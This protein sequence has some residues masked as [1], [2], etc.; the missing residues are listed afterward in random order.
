MLLNSKIICFDWHN[1]FDRLVLSQT[2]HSNNY[3]QIDV[4]SYKIMSQIVTLIDP[5]NRWLIPMWPSEQRLDMTAGKTEFPSCHIHSLLASLSKLYFV[6]TDDH[7]WLSIPGF[8]YLCISDIFACTVKLS[9]VIIGNGNVA[10]FVLAVDDWTFLL[11][12]STRAA[13]GRVKYSWNKQNYFHDKLQM[14][15]STPWDANVLKR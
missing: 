6:A 2:R 3:Q 5:K 9:S 11:I 13:I 14:E 8:T 12:D 4:A 10:T 1:Y 15:A 7:Y